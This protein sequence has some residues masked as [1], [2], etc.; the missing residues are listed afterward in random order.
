MELLYGAQFDSKA[1]TADGIYSLVIHTDGENEG[2]STLTYT[3]ATT[4]ANAVIYVGQGTVV[5]AQDAILTFKNAA[6]AADCAVNVSGD[7]AFDGNGLTLVK[8]LAFAPGATFSSSGTLPT[9]VVTDTF[10][11]NTTAEEGAAAAQPKVQMGDSSHLATTLDLSLIASAIDAKAMTFQSGSKVTVV[12]D[13]K[14]AAQRR[15]AISRDAETG[16]RNGYVALWNAK[17]SDVEFVLGGPGADRYQLES[18]DEGLLLAK[19]PGTT[20]I[21]R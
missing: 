11:P 15:I 12:V 18:T 14:N 5:V 19:K 1:A 20:V 3:N 8:S 2:E 13:P 4:Y 6:T 17:P 16:E 21:L 7:L 9:T 10:A